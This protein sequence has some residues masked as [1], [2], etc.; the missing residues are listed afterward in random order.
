MKDRYKFRAWDGE[1]MHYNVTPWHW[2]F[3]ISLGWHRCENSTGDGFLGSGGKS[4]EFLVPGLAFIEVMQ[5][6]GFK[7]KNGKEIYEGDILHLYAEI[8]EKTFHFEDE[9]GDIENL[10]HDSILKVE[11]SHDWSGYNLEFISGTTKGWMLGK[12]T[13]SDIE[14]I[15]NI[16]EN[17]ELLTNDST[18]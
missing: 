11:W 5:Y 15:G 14:V 2:D 10:I 9:E 7:D 16:Y 4:A 18:L 13:Q 6:T 17:P 12:D 1:K 3:V 8:E